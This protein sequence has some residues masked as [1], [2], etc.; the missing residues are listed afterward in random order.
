MSHDH[1]KHDAKP[2]PFWASR[3]SIGLIVFAAIAAYFLLSEHRTPFHGALSI[4]LLLAFPLVHIFMHG[5]H[6]GHGGR[7]GLNP[8][9]MEDRDSPRAMSGAVISL[10]PDRQ[11]DSIDSISSVYRGELYFFRSTEDRDAFE[12]TQGASLGDCVPSGRSAGAIVQS[13]SRGSSTP[14]HP[15]ECHGED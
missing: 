7:Q 15:Q 13:R 3:Y 6:G 5:G 8:S 2:G 14:A 12:A 10:V 1:A 11:Q 4:L 9:T